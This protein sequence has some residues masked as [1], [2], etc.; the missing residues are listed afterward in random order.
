MALS[1]GLSWADPQRGISA[2][3]KGRTLLLTHTEEEFQ[4]QGV[5]FAWNPTP[6]KRGPSF[7]L[8]HAIGATADDGRMPCCA[9]PPWRCRMPSP[10]TGSNTNT[11]WKQPW[12]M[13]SPPSGTASPSPRPSLWPSPQTAPPMDLLLRHWL[14]Q[15]NG[16]AFAGECSNIGERT[17]GS[18]KIWRAFPRPTPWSPLTDTAPGK[19]TPC[20]C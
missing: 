8:S 18:F 2:E 3:V 7:S 12:P 6:S 9:P 16:I 5:T 11:S 17:A 14:N 20:P 1:A 4:E 15:C 19:V 13:V 10:A